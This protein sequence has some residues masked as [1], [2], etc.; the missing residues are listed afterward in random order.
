[1]KRKDFSKLKIEVQ[2]EKVI[3]FEH[4]DYIAGI[5]P[6]LRGTYATMYFQTPLKTNF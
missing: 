2:K 3:H 5:D 6:N 1:M 4:E